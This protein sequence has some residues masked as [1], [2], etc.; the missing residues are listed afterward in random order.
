MKHKWQKKESK[1]DYDICLQCGIKKIDLGKHFKFIYT[2]DNNW[3]TPTN[4]KYK[5]GTCPNNLK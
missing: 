1:H 5:A 4:Y 2:H 3:L